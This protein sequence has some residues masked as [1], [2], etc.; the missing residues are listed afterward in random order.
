M[1]IA[2][3]TKT[4]RQAGTPPKYVICDKG[5]QFWCKRFKRWCKR[6]KIKPRSGAVGHYGSI[7]VVERFIRTLKD[8]GFRPI[9]VPPNLRKMRAEANAIAAWYNTCRPHTTLGGRTPAEAYRRIAPANK[10]PRWEPRK[11]WPRDAGCAGPEAKTRGDPDVCL[12]LILTY[13]DG[14]KHLPIVKPRCAA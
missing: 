14:Q 9:L 6:R 4:I 10:R 12:E 7:A 2:S 1:V 13:L 3:F 5:T 11:R 8:E